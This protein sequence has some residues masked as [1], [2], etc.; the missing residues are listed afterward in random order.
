MKDEI[1]RRLLGH[2]GTT[3]GLGFI[4]ARVH[5]IIQEPDLS[6]IPISGRPFLDPPMYYPRARERPA[7]VRTFRGAP[8]QDISRPAGQSVPDQEI[9]AVSRQ[10]APGAAPPGGP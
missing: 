4:P 8:P 1:E 10:G 3:P 7:A 6:L 9:G 5:R 2:G